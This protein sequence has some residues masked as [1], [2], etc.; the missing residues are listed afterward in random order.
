MSF[1]KYRSK[2]M[3]LDGYSF[4]SKLEAALYQQ[5]KLLQRSGE[6]ESIKVQDHVYLTDAR[7]QYIADFK[8][9]SKD[10]EEIWHEAKGFET[11]TWRIKRRLWR[12]Y[13]PGKLRVY[14]QSGTRLFMFEEI[15]GGKDG[16][17]E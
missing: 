15:R 5:L 11:P 9:V 7:I 10:G 16:E 6:F 3:A 1:T 2:R 14:K 12:E 4:A 8:T 13:G 17:S